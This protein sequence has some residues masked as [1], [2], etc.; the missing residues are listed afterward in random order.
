MNGSTTS[1]RTGIILQAEIWGRL[2]NESA[3]A[4]DAFCHYREM[5]AKRSIAKVAR[6]I[7]CSERL[8]ERWSSKHRWVVRTFSYDNDLDL[9]K[10]AHYERLSFEISAKHAAQ[11]REVHERALTR[12][13][14]LDVNQLT[15]SQ[16]IQLAKAAMKLEAAA[17]AVW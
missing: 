15:I 10:Q 7:G 4:Y 9:K 16:V 12:L 8:L 11:A 5:G 2:P 1:S 13:S 17:Y 6:A 3:R 14:S